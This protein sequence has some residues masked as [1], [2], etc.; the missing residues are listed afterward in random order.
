[1]PMKSRVVLDGRG[2]SVMPGYTV[3]IEGLC[4]DPKLLALYNQL[5]AA[6][7]PCYVFPALPVA[8]PANGTAHRR[9]TRQ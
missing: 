6:N 1:M 4:T 9:G 2:D 5:N 7:G 3:H 8:G